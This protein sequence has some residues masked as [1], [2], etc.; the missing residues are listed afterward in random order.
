MQVT[1]RLGNRKGNGS[2]LGGDRE[3][4]FRLGGIPVLRLHMA[5]AAICLRGVLSVS[6]RGVSG[7]I[8]RGISGVGVAVF[9]F[10]RPGD[11]HRLARRRLDVVDGGTALGEVF[12][13]IVGRVILGL[14]V[15][16]DRGRLDCRYF[17]V[18]KIK[19]FI[20]LT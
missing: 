12:S 4:A 3:S 9:G 17:V 8:L 18:L 2:S 13:S 15:V 6:L 19:S 11:L 16:D 1:G 20:Y 10:G 7:V 5:V 14:G